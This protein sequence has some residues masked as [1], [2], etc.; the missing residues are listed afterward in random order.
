MP[1]KEPVLIPWADPVLIPLTEPVEIPFTEPVLI[2]LTDPV[3]IP[4]TF[5]SPTSSANAETDNAN[6]RSDA[7]RKTLALFAARISLSYFF[8]Q[9]LLPCDHPNAVVRIASVFCF[10]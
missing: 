8:F 6:T 2:P 1:V 7:P 4:L 9:P 5:A 3:D 10:I